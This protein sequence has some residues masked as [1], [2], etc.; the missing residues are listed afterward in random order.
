M[1]LRQLL[2]VHLERRLVSRSRKDEINR[3]MVE[4][5]EYTDEVMQDAAFTLHGE[6]VR[7]PK[8]NGGIGVPIDTGY[9]S[10]KT[11]FAVGTLP[12]RTV[13]DNDVNSAESKQAQS[14]GAV[15]SYSI[16]NG[17]L[18]VYNDTQ[19]IEMLN[20]GWSQQAPAMFWEAATD[21]MV[22]AINKKYNA[23]VKVL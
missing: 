6:L 5:E 14:R 7:D 11:W 20:K 8:M 21:K 4:I 10:A 1:F 22:R 16:G 17:P 9:A 13:D 23:K 15:F 18:Y 3:I 2:S 12:G 19:Y